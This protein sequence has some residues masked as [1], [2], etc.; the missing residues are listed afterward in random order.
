MEVGRGQL[1]LF[2]RDVRCDI[3]V[4][5]Y[6]KTHLTP[7]FS[8]NN[9]AAASAPPSIPEIDELIIQQAQRLSDQLQAH[10]LACFPS[11]AEKPLRTFSPA[12]AAK[13]L[14]TKGS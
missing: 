11:A 14:G 12:E 2:L 13:F 8:M 3:Y 1:S 4:I 10:R 6:F 5:R 9:L 7:A